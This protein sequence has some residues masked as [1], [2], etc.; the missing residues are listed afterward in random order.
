MY[1]HSGGGTN[2]T[3]LQ[4]LN[5]LAN[6]VKENGTYDNAQSYTQPIRVKYSK[7]HVEYEKDDHNVAIN[8]SSS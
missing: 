2:W 8:S 7:R 4:F 6:N 3:L 5:E 1:M